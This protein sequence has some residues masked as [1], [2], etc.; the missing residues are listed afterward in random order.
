M[1]QHDG[2]A[3]AGRGQAGH[4]RVEPVVV[5]GV[6]L[7]GQEHGPGQVV[8]RLDVVQVRQRPGLEDALARAEQD[9]GAGGSGLEVIVPGVAAGEHIRLAQ[10]ILAELM[11][12]RPA[13][14]GRPVLVGRQGRGQQRM[15]HLAPGERRGPAGELGR[16][17]LRIKIS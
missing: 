13:D 8:Q 15:P 4:Q 2:K 1:G 12:A 9:P 3:A 6:G 11:L 14:P 16:Y 17:P 5:V 7:V 10:V